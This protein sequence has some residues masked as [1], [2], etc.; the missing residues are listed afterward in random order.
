MAV[1]GGLRFLRDWSLRITPP[2]DFNDPFELR[3]SIESVFTEE[4]IDE[5]IE[6][7]A[8]QM[9]ITNIVEM[10][11][12]TFGAILTKQDIADMATCI[13]MPSSSDIETGVVDILQQKIPEFSR[14]N[15]AKCKKQFQSQWVASMQLARESAI[16]RLPEFNLSVKRGF[17]EQFPSML[18]V[19]CL[20]R[21]PNQPLMWAHYADSHKGMVIEFDTTHPTFNRKRSDVDDF[22]FLRPV[23]YS[24]AR[25]E[26]TMQALDA[27]DSF[28]LFALTKADPWSYEEEIRLIWP[29]T[30]ADESVETPVGTIGLLSC[31]S[32]AV[33]SVT[34]GCKAN[35]HL[36][37]EVR[38]AL[39]A[40]TGTSHIVLRRARLHETSFEL[41]YHDV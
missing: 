14:V 22:G 19:L 8:T 25:P 24:K 41:D 28:D 7:E 27:S 35:D 12:S 5:Q 39:R 9:A 32:S 33:V 11:T 10:L 38:E 21:S 15:F 18:G 6:N 31:P 37:N 34:L 20:S 23:T 30:L 16:S 17:T 1:E 40:Q 3:P 29:L 2:A 13:V 4:H 36:A 26:I